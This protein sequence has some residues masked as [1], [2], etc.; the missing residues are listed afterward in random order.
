MRE[1]VHYVKKTFVCHLY[2]RECQASKIFESDY[3]HEGS[4]PDLSDLAD[5]RVSYHIGRSIQRH[6]TRVG[7]KSE[8]KVGRKDDAALDSFG[9]ASDLLPRAI[10]LLMNQSARARL[11]SPDNL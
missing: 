2:P 10:L 7:N 4:K 8:D 3:T 6:N 9:S 1:D 5:R 11:S